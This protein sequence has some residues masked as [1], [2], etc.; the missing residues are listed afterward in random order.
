MVM[1]KE[2]AASP[3]NAVT[4][5]KMMVQFMG[6]F[7]LVYEKRCHNER[8][9]IFSRTR[10]PCQYQYGKTAL[11]QGGRRNRPPLPGNPRKCSAQ[12]RYVPENGIVPV[13]PGLEPAP[14]GLA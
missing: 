8:R 11:P 6:S 10:P 1:R 4:P 9:P 7:P 14:A 13:W 5:E 12:P 2:R 3:K